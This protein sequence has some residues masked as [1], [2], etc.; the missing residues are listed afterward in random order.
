MHEE[1]TL[2]KRLIWLWRVVKGGTSS[3]LRTA[4]GAIIHITDALAKP[5]HELVAVLSPVQSGTGDPSPDNV[6]P[7]SGWTGANIEQRGKNLRTQK[8]SEMTEVQVSGNGSSQITSIIDDGVIIKNMN[9]TEGY[10]YGTSMTT[11]ITKSGDEL[12][13]TISNSTYGIGICIELPEN[14]NLKVYSVSNS[15]HKYV[16]FYDSN[17]TFISVTADNATSFTTPDGTK[18]A[19][20]TFRGLTNDAVTLSNFCVYADGEASYEPPKA[21]ATLP[22]NWQTEAGTIYGGALTLNEDGSSDVV[23]DSILYSADGTEPW[24]ADGSNYYINRNFPDYKT[25]SIYTPICSHFTTAGTYISVNGK[26]NV[27]KTSVPDITSATDF[28]AWVATQYTNNTPLTCVYPLATPQTYHFDN[29]GQLLLFA[30]ENNIWVDASDD[31]TLTYYADGNVSDA[32]ALGILLGGMYSPGGDVSDR[33]ALNIL[34][35]N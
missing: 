11:T 18:Y 17:K 34:L 12:S 25:G 7:I 31:L 19:V 14:K 23:A 1:W 33:E 13:F 4:T 27:K 35:G 6:R 29:V 22:I 32:E 9:L 24:A 2:L 30:G 8:L 3:V 26:W 16:Q 15:L 20:F 5:A 10:A 28:K 21:G